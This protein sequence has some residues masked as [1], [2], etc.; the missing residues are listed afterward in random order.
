MDWME[1]CKYA[2]AHLVM[3]GWVEFM[4]YVL[5]GCII[6][7]VI[8]RVFTGLESNQKLPKQ[9]LTLL[10]RAIRSIIWV[11]VLVQGLRAVG[12]DVISILGAAGV[13]GVAIGFASQ[14][15]LSNLISG[16]FLVSERSFKLGD[17]ISVAGEEGSVESIN[18]LS[19]Y[20]RRPD[21]SLVRIPCETLIKS[22]VTNITG[23]PRRR[24]DMDLGVD[25]SSDL[26]KVKDVILDVIKQEPELL[27]S[28][29][30]TVM[31][32]GFG[33]SSLNL[34]IGAW[35]KTEVYHGLRYRLATAILER[36]NKEGINIP[37]PVRT[38]V[39]QGNS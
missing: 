36:F 8:G 9:V 33:D 2:W 26:T 19:V 39:K 29:A 16:I 14:T 38:I 15:S 27:D 28:P 1:W 12:V 24:I 5:A 10:S 22:P 13:L 30:P 31:F 37:F 7:S 23:S 34:H 20:L 35:C 4:F 18:L 11:L 32:S 17:Y 25:Y 3:N 6:T 21:N